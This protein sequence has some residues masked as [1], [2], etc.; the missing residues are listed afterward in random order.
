MKFS[1]ILLATLFSSSQAFAPNAGAGRFSAL[2]VTES[3]VGVPSSDVIDKSLDGID[4]GAEHDVF[5]PLDGEQPALIRNNNDEVWVP[6]VRG[7]R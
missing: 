7:E 1:T 3:E 4:A 2:K 6:Q 5:D